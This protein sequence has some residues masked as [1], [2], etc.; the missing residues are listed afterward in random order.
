MVS[1]RVVNK[2][3]ICALL[4]LENSSF[5]NIK[6]D[7][8]GISRFDFDGSRVVLTGHND[9]SYLDRAGCPPPRDF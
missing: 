5:W 4:G 9:T 2:I 6:L 3:I 8:A 1:H 7:T